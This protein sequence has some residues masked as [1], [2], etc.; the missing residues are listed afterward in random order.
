M[1]SNANCATGLPLPARCPANPTVPFTK[2]N[3]KISILI[4]YD[5][6]P[7]NLRVLIVSVTECGTGTVFAVGLGRYSNGVIRKGAAA[8][9]EHAIF[10]RGV[11][12]R[13]AN[14]TAPGDIC[15]GL[16]DELDGQSCEVGGNRVG[17][18]AVHSQGDRLVGRGVRGC[19]V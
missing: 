13:E 17:Q 2:C 14:S 19:N 15:G 3:L 9:V 4:P 16:S 1:I 8:E 12:C 6:F 11:G 5:A 10:E 7:P 18:G